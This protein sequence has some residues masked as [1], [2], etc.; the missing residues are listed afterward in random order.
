[1]AIKLL[2][3]K[4]GNIFETKKSEMFETSLLA[5]LIFLGKK[6]YL[7]WNFIPNRQIRIGF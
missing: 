1:M 4:T 6:F 7:A 3:W 5:R 2:K